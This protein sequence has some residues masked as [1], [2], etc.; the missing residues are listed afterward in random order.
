MRK[1]NVTFGGNSSWISQ[2]T[3]GILQFLEEA[4]V[5]GVLLFY[6]GMIGPL[7]NQGIFDRTS[8]LETVLG[9]L[10]FAIVVPL[11]LINL[12]QAVRVL[13]RSP[14]L[15]VLTTFLCVSLL[16]S[17]A[18]STSARGIFLLLRASAFAL[19]FATRFSL[20]QQFRLLAWCLGISIVGSFLLAVVLPNYAI[21][22]SDP[23]LSGDGTQESIHAGSWKGVFGHKNVLS[24]YM[25]LSTIVFLLSLVYSR[26]YK[27]VMW[28]GLA[29]S[30]VLVALSTSRTGLAVLL[31]LVFLVPLYSRLKF[32]SIASSILPILLVLIGGSA[33]IFFVS[34]T[35]M[36]LGTL[37]RDATLTGRT[38]LWTASWEQ[39][40]QRPLVGHGYGAFWR[41][42]LA[43]EV[44]TKVGWAAPHSHNGYIDALIDLGF[45]G[46]ALAIVSSIVVAFYGLRF[47][48]QGKSLEGIWI[49]LFLTFLLF[50]N[51]TESSFFR[52]TFLWLVY[53]SISLS[54]ASDHL[55]SQSDE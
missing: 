53:F 47:L 17:D 44:W 24:R 50:Y 5:V 23:G 28:I 35:E 34:N 36:V 51:F 45:V 52:Q 27:V 1:I 2:T 11:L 16:W 48:K 15:I 25:V 4:F 29:S 40:M 22:G 33:L 6:T 19:Y 26:G 30:I 49:L 7:M 12:K 42:M 14:A 20:K 13:M 3:S 41:T 46:L 21:M 8:R 32:K 39:A 37:G 54:A 55:I 18:Y 43:Y 9:A 10:I 31:F 38:E